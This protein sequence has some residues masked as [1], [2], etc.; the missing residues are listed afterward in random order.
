MICRLQG[1]EVGMPS[2]HSRRASLLHGS[3]SRLT[4]ISLIRSAVGNV[5]SPSIPVRERI[6]ESP[7]SFQVSATAKTC[8]K[9][10]AHRRRGTDS[11]FRGS[12]AIR[13]KPSARLRIA[14]MP[15][16]STGPKFAMTRLRGLP[17]FSGSRKLSHR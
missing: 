11:T 7:R 4:T 9:S 10:L 13:E 17:P 5:V 8:P 3:H 16:F 12:P 14:S 2:S 1:V 15:I 6:T